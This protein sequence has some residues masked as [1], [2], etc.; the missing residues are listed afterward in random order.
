MLNPSPKLSIVVPT[1]NV[2]ATLEK[3]LRSV[4]S[5]SWRDYEILVID[6]GSS[7]STMRIVAAFEADI[8]SHISEK[9]GGVY[10]AMNKGIAAARGEWVYFLGADDELFDPLVLQRVFAHETGGIDMMYGDVYMGKTRRRYDGPFDVYR[11]SKANICHQAIFLKREVF[12]KVGAFN[13][14]YPLWA[15]YELNLRLFG[16]PRIRMKYLDIVI[17]RYAADGLSSQKEDAAFQANRP[18]LLRRHLNT[19][20]CT[21]QILRYWNKLKRWRY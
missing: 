16:N 6:G 19:S 21:F 12:K 4:T 18:E 7:D 13:L 15:D 2:E 9:D 11:I 3:C 10:D 14:S 5:Q 1:F 17:A 8:A 20:F